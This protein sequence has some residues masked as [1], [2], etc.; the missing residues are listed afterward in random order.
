LA[1]SQQG[2]EQP[3]NQRPTILYIARHT[4]VHNP[5][6]ILY[7]RLPRYRL[8]DLGHQQADAT[9][10]VLAEEPV[11]AIYSSPRL[12]ARQT[13]AILAA[14]HPGLNV[15]IT[16][17]LDEVQTAWQGRPHSELE[18]IRFNF[19]GNPLHE[20][21]ETLDEIWERIQKFVRQARARHKGETVVAV[22]HGDPVIIARAGYLGLPI[23]IESLRLPYVYPGKGS[24]TRLTFCHDEDTYP[25]S[26]EYY[27]PNS[28]DPAWSQG[29]VRLGASGHAE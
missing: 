7:G 8:S 28:D 29:W 17:L 19:Y 14:R 23:T 27:D 26:V 15:R 13:A 16:K 11:S 9:A 1:K 24:I 10:S 20:S 12:R 21:D 2:D 3:Q 25:Q 6:D 4:D 22:S 5:A 18:E